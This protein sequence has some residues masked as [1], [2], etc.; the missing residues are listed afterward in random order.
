MEELQGL[1]VQQ[2]F[3]LPA[4]S[5]AKLLAGGP[6]KT[7]IRLINIMADPEILEWI[8][9]GQM[10]AMTGYNLPGWSLEK[11]LAF[12]KSCHEKGLSAMAIKLRPY[13]ERLDPPILDYLNEVGL[14]VIEVS[15]MVPISQLIREV[16]DALFEQKN[17]RAERPEAVHQRFMDIILSGG[18]PFEITGILAGYLQNPVVFEMSYSLDM[19][20]DWR[21]LT[22]EEQ[23]F[24]M[25]DYGRF[26][27]DRA[28]R[29][30]HRITESETT[31]QGHRIRRIT[32]PIILRENIYGYLTSW[33]WY[34]P[35]NSHDRSIME[36]AATVM[37]LL[38]MQSLSVREVEVKYASEFFEDL[39]SEDP[40]KRTR[41]M[42]LRTYFDVRS[43]RSYGV[44]LTELRLQNEYV[45]ENVSLAVR[46]LIHFL[47]PSLERLKFRHALEGIISTRAN[48][49]QVLLGFPATA[50]PQGVFQELCQEI[51]RLVAESF[52]G[53]AADVGVGR[54]KQSHTKIRESYEEAAHARTIHRLSGDSRRIFYEDLGIYQLLFQEGSQ[55]QM[56]DFCDSVFG[57]LEDYDEKMKE[58]LYTTLKAYFKTG[59]N[60]REMARELYLHYNSVLYRLNRFREI[61]GRDLR[62][63]DQRLDVAMALRIRELLP[64]SK[65]EELS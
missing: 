22:K 37:S 2:L 13:M 49:L 20:K 17:H 28:K 21:S 64:R 50:D 14:P 38:L 55:A 24:L 5:D 48:G 43:A 39:I 45:Q 7:A 8:D 42:E 58:Q 46:R 34:A 25:K 29:N 47:S 15:P 9:E 4:L 30:A 52:P 26:T 12:F 11:R 51:L 54:M 31:R 41:A 53:F 1:T 10:L 27:A 59:G 36:V 61:T 65:K 23:E 6:G 3:A 40:A 62:E 57:P 44:L 56:A 63:E 32:I 18:G 16:T 35:L 60:L 33:S 19:V